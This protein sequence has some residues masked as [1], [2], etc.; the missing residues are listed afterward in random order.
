MKVNLTVKMILFFLVVV[1]VGVISSVWVV[2][3]IQQVVRASREVQQ[4]Y[5][6]T[7]IKTNH[8]V[9]NVANQVVNIRGYLL[10]GQ[11]NYA[12]EYQRIAK[13]NQGLETELIQSAA[14]EQERKQVQEIKAVNDQYSETVINKVI[15]LKRAGQDQEAVQ[16]NLTQLGPIARGLIEKT[17]A[18]G[19]FS[20][21]QIIDIFA[22]VIGNAEATKNVAITASI[23]SALLGI[24]VGFFSARSIAKPVKALAEVTGYIAEGNLQHEVEVTRQDEIGQLQRS[25]NGMVNNLRQ[26]VERVQNESQHVSAASEELTA[27]AAQSAQAAN[28]VAQV[29]GEVTTG[30][31]NQL[32]A[33]DNTSTVVEQMSAGVQQIAANA[34]MVAGTSAKSAE[35][36]QEGSKAVEKAIRQMGQIEETV[37]HSAEVVTKLGTRSKEIGQIV[38]TIS[39]IAGQT[40]LLA[41]NA[42]IEAARAGEQGRGFSVVAEEVRKLAEQ[43]QEAAKRIASLIAEI[44]TDTDSAVVAMNEGTKEV[45]IGNEVVNHAG[46]S[47]QE[48]FGLIGN[49]T[50]QVREISAAIQELASGSQQIVTAVRDIDAISKETAGQSQTVSAATEEQS[51][52][53]EEIAAS[54]QALA[55]MAEGLTQAI[56]KFK[57]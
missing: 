5:L 40:N 15:P 8:I 23:I 7:L 22:Q 32:T 45:R 6:P 42:A 25:I 38:D 37:I 21:K 1:L 44:Q 53:M 20:E 57:V 39:G 33:L 29:I 56:S 48:I 13:E 26:L 55:K 16:F 28:Q 34:N 14:S 43:S 10:T 51:A 50:D 41:L 12:N 30:A 52:T 17:N 19:D 54:S 4:Q 24:L 35:A 46:K 36:A 18:Y 49:V 47:F 11:E 31:E 3:N 27:S 9:L 2:T